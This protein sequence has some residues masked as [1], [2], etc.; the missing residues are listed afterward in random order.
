[1]CVSVHW[2]RVPLAL[3]FMLVGCDFP[4]PGEPGYFVVN[5]TSD[6]VDA[7]PG[8]LVCATASGACTLRAAIQESNAMAGENTIELPAGTYL[9]TLP[10]GGGASQG[11]LNVTSQVRILGAGTSSTRIDGNGSVLNTRIFYLESGALHLSDVTLQNGGSQNV[12]AGGGIRADTGSLFLTRVVLTGNEAFSNGGAIA[13]FAGFLSLTDS[14]IDS[15]VV[16]S[17]GGG[18]S[19]GEETSIGIT[20]CTFSNNE[21]TLGGAI[22]SFGTLTMENSTISGNSGSAGTGGII[23]VGTMNLNNVTITNN[24]SNEGSSGRAGGIANSGGVLNLRNSL[25]AGNLNTAGGSPDC[26]GTLTSQGFNLIQS[27]TGCTLVGTTT[28]N[29]TGVNPLLGA[30]ANNGGLTRTH[31]IGSGSPA[32]EAGNPAAPGS[33]DAACRTTDQRGV[34]RPQGTRCDMGA[35]ERQ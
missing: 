27:T 23:N 2:H 22:Q 3:L 32:R 13:Q 14:T 11:D 35:F 31:S 16:T 7:F 34:S 10:G 12:N 1:M 28:G 20:R 33:S 18:L 8:N 17:R 29:L 5:S 6:A 30:L 4:E 25:I 15:N 21:S 24:T 26:A 9:L 19:A